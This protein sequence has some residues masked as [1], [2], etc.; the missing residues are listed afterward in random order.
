MNIR[1]GLVRLL[2]VIWSICGVSGLL[3]VTFAGFSDASGKPVLLLFGGC[4]SLG[5][6]IFWRVSIWVVDGFFDG[7][8]IDKSV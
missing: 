8:E 2:A 7:K 6:Y 1:R 4:V 5:S 3:I